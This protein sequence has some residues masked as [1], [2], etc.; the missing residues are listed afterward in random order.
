[1]WCRDRP[2]AP[3]CWPC[4]SFEEPVALSRAQRQPAD[5]VRMLRD[6]LACQQGPALT[7]TVRGRPLDAAA[8]GV[9]D[10]RLASVEALA[11][12]YG[13]PGEHAKAAAVLRTE[14]VAHP[15]RESPAAALMLP[16]GR[17]GRQSDAIAG[18]TAP[19]GC[20]PRNSAWTP[21]RRSRRRTPRCCAPPSPPHPVRA[22]TG[23]RTAAQPVSGRWPGNG[24]GAVRSSRPI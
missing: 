3:A 22:G 10:L 4:R 19:G 21:A 2:S 17:S 5:A 23:S 8:G 20:S 13:R 18:T 6:A 12:A 15:L 7:G 16:L 1:M 24:W 9:E 14:A 11:E